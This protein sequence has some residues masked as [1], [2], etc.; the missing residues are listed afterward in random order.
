MREK[1]SEIRTNDGVVDTFICHPDEGGPFPP[2]IIYMD[3]PGMR[4]E[5]RD[6]ARRLGTVGYYVMLPNLYYRTGREGNYGYELSKIRE[7]NNE[8]EKMFQVMRSLTNAHV[9]ADTQPLMDYARNDDSS[10]EGPFGCVGYCMSGQFVVS[11]GAAYPRD[12]AAV[13]S[14]YGVGIVTQ[15]EDSP[16]I[17]AHRI[18]GSLYLAFASHDQWVPESLLDSLPD[19]MTKAGINYRIEIYPDTE[20][21]FAFPE[22]PVYVKS[23][24]ERHWE[25]LFAM[26]DKELRQ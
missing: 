6:M 12:F 24:G 8:R 18:K 26:F 21:G 10:S 7:D 23:A 25:R 22:R 3:A 11:I 9:V 2:I 16:H 13:A 19:I 5:L 17:N 4:E 20:H 1:V 15:E 14:F